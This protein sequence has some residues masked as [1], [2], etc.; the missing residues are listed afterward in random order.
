MQFGNEGKRQRPAVAA[1]CS[2]LRSN[3]EH[4]STTT[5]RA[6]RLVPSQVCR[7]ENIAGPINGDPGARNPSIRTS[8]KAVENAFVPAAGT[9]GEFEDDTAAAIERAGVSLR[10]S[11]EGRCPKNVSA[12]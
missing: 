10:T 1:P 9:W 2:V 7:T 8:V 6:G 5:P 4:R 12:R 3:F 11:S